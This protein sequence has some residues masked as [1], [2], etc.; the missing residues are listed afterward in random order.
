MCFRSESHSIQWS[1]LYFWT[2]WWYF[3]ARKCTMLLRC[4]HMSFIRGH[5]TTATNTLRIVNFY[6]LSSSSTLNIILY[7]SIFVFFLLFFLLHLFPAPPSLF[8][9]FYP[10][11]GADLVRGPDSSSTRL[12]PSVFLAAH[13]CIRSSSLTHGADFTPQ[14]NTR[15]SLPTGHRT[16]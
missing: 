5:I 14:W 6:H 10:R 12:F 4:P 2:R 7:S 9:C 13:P 15:F 16:H 8:D 1:L 3:L 11:N